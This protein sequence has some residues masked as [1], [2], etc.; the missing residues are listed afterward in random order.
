MA[1]HFVQKY[2]ILLELHQLFYVNG[3]FVKIISNDILTNLNP[4][5]LAY[6][7]MG[8]GYYSGYGFKLHTNG[9][10]FEG[11]QGCFTINLY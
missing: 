10:S 1:C 5:V 9:F 7:A 8:D 4:I 11:Y 3:R 6:L 2:S